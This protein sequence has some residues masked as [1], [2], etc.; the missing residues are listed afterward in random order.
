V[1]NSQAHEVIGKLRGYWPTPQM[2]D[3]EERV[4]MDLLTD[5]RKSVRF[6][7]AISTISRLSG[8]QFRPRPGAFTQLSK[9]G[10]NDTGTTACP[11]CGGSSWRQVEF[12]ELPC[13]RGDECCFDL[14]RCQCVVTC[15][16]CEGGRVPWAAD[17]NGPADYGEIA[18]RRGSELRALLSPGGI[19]RAS[20]PE[21]F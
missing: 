6:E 9:P 10:R 2:D 16:S 15:T 14:A 18:K 21:I 7:T 19:K 8:E 17:P 12:S 11:K 5:P 13:H 1:K 20:E 4:W 3:D